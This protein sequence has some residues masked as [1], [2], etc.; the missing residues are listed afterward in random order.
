MKKWIA[1][2]IIC[3]LLSVSISCAVASSEVSCFSSDTFFS[4]SVQPT[5]SGVV[6][7][8]A[9]LKLKCSSV[10]VTSCSLEKFEDGS[11][12]FVKYLSTPEAKT[13]TNRYSVSKDYS[14]SLTSGNTY[15]FK[16]TF[17]AN[18]ETLSQ[19]SPALNY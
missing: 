3:A 1:Y 16:A 11:W 15:R 10:S 17:S 9:R 2:I 6:A 14:S 4:V 13:N 12:K 19:T 8:N 18:G 7:F 5:A